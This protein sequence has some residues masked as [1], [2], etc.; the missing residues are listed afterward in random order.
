[1]TLTSKE[2]IHL[3]AEVSLKDPEISELVHNEPILLLAF[4]VY[5]SAIA[6][7]IYGEDRET[8]LEFAKEA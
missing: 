6:K 3:A 2:F 8:A 5:A 4:G 1:M 7:A